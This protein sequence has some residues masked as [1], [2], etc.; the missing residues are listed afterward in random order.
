MQAKYWATH[1]KILNENTD[2]GVSHLVA[3]CDEV[4]FLDSLRADGSDGPWIAP[5]SSSLSAPKLVMNVTGAASD[6]LDLER[7]RDDEPGL[8]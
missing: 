6:D 3:W 8:K 5:P 2:H 1:K 4:R 7:E